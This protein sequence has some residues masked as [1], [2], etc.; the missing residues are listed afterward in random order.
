[1]QTPMIQNPFF[2]VIFPFTVRL[3]PVEAV[4]FA[5]A[6]AAGAGDAGLV[7]VGL[8]EVEVAVAA[9]DPAVVGGGEEGAGEVV[10]AWEAGGAAFDRGGG[11]GGGGGGGWDGGGGGGRVRFGLDRVLVFGRDNFDAA[12]WS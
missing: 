8:D 12:D 7:G 5:V 3:R 1:M 11:G 4:E 10:V 6:F 9:L 2:R